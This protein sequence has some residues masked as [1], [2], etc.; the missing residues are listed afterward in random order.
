M[1]PLTHS[2]GCASGAFF[3]P[4]A[5]ESLKKRAAVPSAFLPA[6]VK[7]LLVFAKHS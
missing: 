2:A 3:L 6:G 1:D 4:A 7:K 5:S